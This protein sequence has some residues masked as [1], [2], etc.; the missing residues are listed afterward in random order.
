M[1]GKILCYIKR[2]HTGRDRAVPS[3]EL[4]RRFGLCGAT[5]RKHINTLRCRG[6]PICSDESGYYY[7]ATY[8]EL[9]DTIRQLHSRIVKI[10]QARNG[11]LRAGNAFPDESGQISL[12]LS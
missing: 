7:A 10:A 12:P 11:L 8:V 1:E 3:P 5:L 6:Y 4:E 9:S 2:M